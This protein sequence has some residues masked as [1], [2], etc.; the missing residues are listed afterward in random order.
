MLKLHQQI[1]TP[2]KHTAL[3]KTYNIR[4][5]VSMVL[6]LGA[7]Q[8]HVSLADTQFKANHFIKR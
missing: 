5:H 1:D 4:S 7:F 2:S 8:A 3:K 6:Q